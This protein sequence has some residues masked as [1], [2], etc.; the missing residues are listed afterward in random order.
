MRVLLPIQDY[1]RAR[2]SLVITVH[3]SCHNSRKGGAWLCVLL[4]VNHKQLVQDIEQSVALRHRK[5]GSQYIRGTMT[6]SCKVVLHN[7]LPIS[8]ILTL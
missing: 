1:H 2:L 6:G 5:Q 7:V 3:P 8:V 4:F